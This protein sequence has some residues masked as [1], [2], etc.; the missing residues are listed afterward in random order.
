MF[1]PDEV[2]KDNKCVDIIK[3]YFIETSIHGLKYIFETKRAA[4][5]RLFWLIAVGTLWT[6]GIVLIYKV[7]D[8]WQTS[9]VLVS[10]DST[11]TPI[12]QIPFP[13]V[14]FCNMN[15]VLKS[16]AQFVEEK[17][18]EEPEKELWKKE[19]LFVEEVCASHLESHSEVDETSQ[20]LNISGHELHEF[21]ENLAQPCDQLLLR[22]LFDK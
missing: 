5:E 20:T 8:K 15:K 16:R 4:I 6:C 19:L 12:T 9:P 1:P 11:V 10:F 14:T 18:D 7:I 21:L 2:Q 3:K 17:R 13:A 22:Y